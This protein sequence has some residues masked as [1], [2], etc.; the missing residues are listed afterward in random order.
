MKQTVIIS[1]FPG[2]GKTHATTKLNGKLYDIIDSDS[3]NF[4]WVKDENGDNTDVRNP[5]FPQ[6]YIDH[7]K[8]NI[9]KV[10]IIFVSSH[11]EVRQAL[12][13]NHMKFI[14][15]SPRQNMKSE[16]MNRFAQRGNT[17]KFIDFMDTNWDQFIDDIYKEKDDYCIVNWL[18]RNH[19]YLDSVYL[20]FVFRTYM[21]N[22]K[23]V[24]NE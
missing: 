9:G 12:K 19:L 10:D 11:K 15:V 3:S 24:V 5:N 13:E 1:A 4:S 8:D 16:W 14:L 22:W 2:C 6:N 23:V 7:I 21:P 18:N 20:D 17:K